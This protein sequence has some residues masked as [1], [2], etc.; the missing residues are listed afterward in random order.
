MASAMVLAE[1]SRDRETSFLD[2]DEANGISVV[3]R[4]LTTVI[5]SVAFMI[6]VVV[7]TSS[8]SAEAVPGQ[9][10]PAQSALTIP[11]FRSVSPLMI[12]TADPTG[13]DV[14]PTSTQVD[15][16]PRIAAVHPKQR[17]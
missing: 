9:R 4:T 13:A 15:D 8:L 11:A 5:V 14:G 12:Q 2:L 10:V 1:G 3:F 17:D 16:G 7:T 6:M